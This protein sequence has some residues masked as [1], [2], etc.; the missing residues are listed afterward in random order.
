LEIIMAY[1]VQGLL[2]L[3]LTSPVTAPASN[4]D[5]PQFLGPT[6]DGLSTETG[7][8]ATWPKEGPPE[9]WK[10]DVGAGFSGAVVAGE[11]LILFHRVDDKEVVEGLEAT[12]GKPR[13]KY[14]YETKYRDAFGKGDGPRATPLIAGE[15][16]YTL[17]AEGRLSCVNLKSGEK[18]WDHNLVGE[19]KPRKG[20]FGVGTSPILEGDR[21][22][23]NVGA[24]GAG[25]VAFN[26]SDGKELWK[27]TDQEAS[28]S[29]P[30]A[31]T[32][33]GVRH[34][35]FFTRDG[36]VSLDP[37]EGKERFS[38]KWRSRNNASVNAA[39]PVLVEDRLFLSASYGT[40]AILLKVHKD[41]VDPVWKNDESLS[42]H[43][44]TSI[45]HEGYLYGL[46]G[47]Q[48][49]GA[50]LRCVD[51][52]TGKVQW[53]KEGFGCASMIKADGRLIAMTEGGDLV[54]L[55]PSA[56]EY[57]EK[58]RASALGSP[59]RAPLALANGRLYA[60]DAKTLICWDL[61]K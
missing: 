8:L 27:A 4:G 46:D 13:W 55:E 3:V 19:Y 45:Y 52:K 38:M 11:W 35:F 14:Q 49:E 40:G 41:K 22:L 36:L 23:I 37:K 28:Y 31:A 32:I 1:S 61:R 21:L 44:D 54:L 53:T 12:S 42:N 2:C 51:F 5:W 20:F 50:R 15:V 43:Y 18:V 57:R 60:R 30:V 48:E 33:D 7:L 10:R 29:S 34:V 16:V 58:A 9:A 25:I 17:G 6:R 56:K 26:A 59:C 39:T 47:R 24:N